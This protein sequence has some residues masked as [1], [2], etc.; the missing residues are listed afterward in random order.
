VKGAVLRCG[1]RGLFMPGGNPMRSA[2]SRVVEIIAMIFAHQEVSDIK[3]PETRSALTGM[4]HS[5]RRRG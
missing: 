3:Q 1:A 5:R 4:G 2:I